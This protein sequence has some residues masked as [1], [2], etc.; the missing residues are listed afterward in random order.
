MLCGLPEPECNV[1]LGD[2]LFFIGRVDLYLRAWNIAIEYEGGQHRTDARQYDRDLGRY[3]ELAA[4]GVLTIRV[5]N[6]AMRRPREVAGRIHR[7]LVSRGYAGPPPWFG[8]EWV[9]AFEAA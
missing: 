3:E 9:A 8:P 5:G 6:V 1:D 7:A 4:S 2:E